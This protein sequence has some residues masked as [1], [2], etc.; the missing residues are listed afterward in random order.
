MLIAYKNSGKA[1]ISIIFAQEIC[2]LGKLQNST[3]FLV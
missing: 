1:T 3:N 2:R